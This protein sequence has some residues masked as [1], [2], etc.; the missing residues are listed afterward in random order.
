MGD[1]QKDGWELIG[2]DNNFSCC[3]CGNKL[4]CDRTSD[5]E[6][7][8]AMLH[9]YA[10]LN[11]E[12]NKGMDNNVKRYICYKLYIF[13]K[14]GRLGAGNRKRVCRCVELEIKEN[15]SSKRYKGF[16]SS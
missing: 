16:I 14:W 7:Q 6:L 9:L 5:E 11:D 2:S 4:G 10:D 1:D 8:S 3:F 15:F 13:W 12:V